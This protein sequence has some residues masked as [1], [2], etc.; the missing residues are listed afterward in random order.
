MK[1]YI[2]DIIPK[3]QRFSQKLNEITVLQ[4]KHWIVLDEESKNKVVFIFREKNNQ[5][6]I[7][8][9]GIIEKGTWDY[10]GN[11]SLL[12]DRESGSYLFKHGFIDDSVLALK[13]DGKEEYLV[14]VNEKWFDI[15]L[16]SLERVLSFLSEK[17]L[18]QQPENLISI[19]KTGC[20]EID[21]NEYSRENLI[22]ALKRRVDECSKQGFKDLT[23]IRGI[24]MTLSLHPNPK[25]ILGRY[26]QLYNID[27]C[28]EIKIIGPE[29]SIINYV[30]D[31][32]IQKGITQKV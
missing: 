3:I 8:I 15:K 26:E 17:Y 12:I 22:F 30:L 29:K 7:S 23:V 10:L 4:N 1:T 25:L 6:L 32:L 13:V 31:P 28:N 9:N 16:R 14:L 20:N 18:S 5:L 11:N 19:T 24:I 21:S 2:L 27:L